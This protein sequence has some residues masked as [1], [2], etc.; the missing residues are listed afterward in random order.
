MKCTALLPLESDFSKYA[1]NLSKVSTV[2]RCR[3]V[4]MRNISK[5]VFAYSIPLT[6]LTL[7]TLRLRCLF[8]SASENCEMRLL[9]ASCLFVSLSVLK[10]QPDSH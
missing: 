7:S 9:A 6:C 2:V 10:A 4:I 3:Y 1:W 5:H 8:L